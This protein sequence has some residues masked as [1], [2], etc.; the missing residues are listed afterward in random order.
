VELVLGAIAE[1]IA[2]G[3][4]ICIEEEGCKTIVMTRRALKILKIPRSAYGGALLWGISR[5]RS[6]WSKPREPIGAC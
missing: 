5:A 3:I 6:A 4:V 1:Q 2:Y